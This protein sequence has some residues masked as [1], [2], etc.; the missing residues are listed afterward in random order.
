MIPEYD[1]SNVKCVFGTGTA[2]VISSVESLIFKDKVLKFNNGEAGELELKLF[3]EIT[4]IQYG[5]KPDIY[6][7]LNYI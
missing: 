1:L 2:A 5:L 7:W 3:N 4:S 6:N